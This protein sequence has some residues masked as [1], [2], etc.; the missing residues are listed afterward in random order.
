MTVW[1]PERQAKALAAVAHW[2]GTPH[3]DC[4]AVVGVGVDCIRLVV[5][6]LVASEV[7]PPFSF[8]AY[9]T[10]EGL[11]DRSDRMLDGFNRCT[12]SHHA[13]KREP[14]FGDIAVFR[15]GRMSGHCAFVLGDKLVHSLAQRQV[16]VSDYRS[17]R[18]AIDRLI[19]LDAIGLRAQ[20]STLWLNTQV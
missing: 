20:P 10:A 9:N 14:L 17:F 1:T 18:P 2:R 19:R 7:T 15:T 16:T 13:D 8:P 12:F 3:R 11:H 4:V 6:I 5:E